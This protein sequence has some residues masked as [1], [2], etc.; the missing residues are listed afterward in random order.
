MAAPL[1]AP[2]VASGRFS[3]VRFART[4][5]SRS[6]ET[7]GAMTV[8]SNVMVEPSVLT[9]V[10]VTG[11]SDEIARET[12]PE[13]ETTEGADDDHVRPTPLTVA[14]RVRFD[15]TF[16]SAEFAPSICANTSPRSRAAVVAFFCSAVG[17]LADTSPDVSATS[18]N[19]TSDTSA[20]SSGSP[21]YSERPR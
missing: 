19:L 16:V 8:T 4:I 11:V 15:V 6:A 14:G 7:V 3:V 9:A 13:V 21:W 1:T 20:R 2:V 18:Q 10:S 17:M 5:A 12:T